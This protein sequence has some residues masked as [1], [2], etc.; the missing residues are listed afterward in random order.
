MA[1]ILT[2]SVPW[3]DGEDKMHQLLRVPYQD[4][5][6]VPFLT[7]PAA[8]LMKQSPLLAIG[9]L[10]Q[11]GRPW[12]SVWGGEEGFA[13]ATS[14][15]SFDIRTPVGRTYDPVVESLL[16]NSTGNSGKVMAF[17]AV[18]LETRRRVKLSG[19][20]DT[21]SLDIPDEDERIRAG[22]ANLTVHVDG[23]L[24]NCPKY[25]NAKRIVPASPEPKLIS[26][27]P[28][29]HP[30][31]IDMLNRA[32]TLF[33]SSSH[34]G[35]D[36]DTN[37]RGG[38]PGF[39]RVISNQPSGAVFVYPEYSGN[40]LYQ[41][42][43]NLQTTPSAGFVFPDFDTGNALF[44]TGTTEILVGKDA[45]AVLPRSNIV[46]RVT[47]TA[48]RFVEKA[49]SFRGIPGKPSPYNPSVRY[50]TSERASAAALG[51][52]ESTV[53]ATLIGKELI[54]PSIGRF[55]FRISDLKEAGS[56]TPGQYATFSFY[57]ELDMGYSHMRDDDPSSINDDYVRTFTVSSSPGHLLP[58]GEFEITARKHG[59][60]TSALFRTSERAGLEVP[61]KGFGG[62]F[63][64]TQQTSDILPFIAG[65]IGITPVLAHLPVIDVSRLRLFWSISLKDIGL[66]L[67]TFKR[68]PKL[69]GS[70]TVFVTGVDH[71]SQ[72]SNAELENVAS[73]GAQVQR[74]RMKAQDIDLSL[75]EVWYFCGSPMLKVP[76][77][78]WLAS[79]KVVYEDFDY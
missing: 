15:S 33:I 46:V 17:L 12:A 47:V 22:I 27:T 10:D 71:R 34:G 54:T 78:N 44:A 42:L 79:K 49:L 53:T 56:W 1:A 11:E 7:R 14:H 21:G 3:H 66:V 26:E 77:F 52:R 40:R 24:G 72:Q 16:L 67:D 55:R 2:T 5:P 50:L 75:A 25:L 62:D 60:V 29:L 65:G 30:S 20:L 61:L 48:A 31:A 73:S 32:D 39:A 74:R 23:S 76:V 41:T 58:D 51:N 45:S 59:N 13:T 6:T 63:Q 28:Q 35:E 57:D 70:T 9:A 38:P 18:D 4:N 8:L 37:I 69:R 64:L 68:F 43:G 36:M 19:K